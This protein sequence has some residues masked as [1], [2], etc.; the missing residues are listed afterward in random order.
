MFLPVIGCP[1]FPGAELLPTSAPGLFQLLP[2]DQAASVLFT[3]DGVVQTDKASIARQPMGLAVQL[4]PVEPQMQALCDCPVSDA[5]QPHRMDHFFLC[6][7]H[8]LPPAFLG[9]RFLVL[10]VGRTAPPFL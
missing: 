10:P 6:V 2:A 5:L 9:V 4:H 3:P 7:R 1:A 8:G